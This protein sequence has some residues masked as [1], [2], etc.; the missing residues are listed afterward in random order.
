MKIRID[1]SKCNSIIQGYS[2]F[3]N[4]MED[5]WYYS[6]HTFETGKS[7]GLISEYMQGCM[8]LSYLI[9][10]K[11]ELKD[12]LEIYID[13]RKT[14]PAGLDD[15]SWNIEPY[16][17]NYKNLVV[18]KSIEK[19]LK[20][21]FVSDTFEQIAKAFVLTEPRYDRKLSQLSGERWRASAAIGYASG[22]RIFYGP[23]KSS[24][25]YSSMNQLPEII[26]FLTDHDCMVLLP[27][28][29]DKYIPECVDE[30]IY[31]QQDSKL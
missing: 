30:C 3:N 12:G 4:G 13:D 26:R 10:G 2:H 19:A 21:G 22:K 25:H 28:G 1:S 31:I 9:G 23:Y 24:N 8:Y 15:I 29:S 6:D 18:K 14:D 16:Y 5:Y 17:E 27:V 7:Y 20:Q 11:I